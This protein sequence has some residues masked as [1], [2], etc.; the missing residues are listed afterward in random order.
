M[1]T[2]ACLCL[3]VWFLR[4]EMLKKNIYQSSLSIS[5]YTEFVVLRDVTHSVR[6]IKISN[7]LRKRQYSLK[8]LRICYIRAIFHQTDAVAAADMN[9]FSPYFLYTFQNIHSDSHYCSVRALV[10]FVIS[11]PFFSF[12]SKSLS[13][14]SFHAL[15]FL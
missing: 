12:Q 14:F 10:I 5:T 13:D 2:R 1:Y 7:N 9:S 11:F 15:Q 4:T 6:S 8:I 3:H